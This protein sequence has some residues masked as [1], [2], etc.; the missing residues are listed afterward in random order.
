MVGGV[1]ISAPHGAADELPC[2]AGPTVLRGFVSDFPLAGETAAE[3]VVSSPAP[4]PEGGDQN[5]AAKTAAVKEA[6]GSR[7]RAVLMREN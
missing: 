7:R 4:A 1:E 5:R 3:A 2:G 6:R